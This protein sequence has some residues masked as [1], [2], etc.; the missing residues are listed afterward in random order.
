MS[1]S[2]TAAV[3]AAR[4][5]GH[6]RGRSSAIDIRISDVGEVQEKEVEVTQALLGDCDDEKGESLTQLRRDRRSRWLV[7]G[8]IASLILTSF[9][10]YLVSRPEK[11]SMPGGFEMGFGTELRL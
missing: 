9:V 1:L 3:N 7:V 5:I 6:R 4:I 8:W 11:R 2:P 10:T